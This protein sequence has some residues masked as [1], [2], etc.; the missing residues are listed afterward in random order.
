M[1]RY[2]TALVLL[3]LT[4]GGLFPQSALAAL[5]RDGKNCYIFVHGKQT[6][7]QSYY[8][9]GTAR[10]YWRDPTG[11]SGGTIDV[12]MIY[13]YDRRSFYVVNYNGTAA[14]WDTTAGGTVAWQI[15]NAT[16]GGSD[17]GGNRCAYS[18]TQGG[19]FIVIAHSMG[20]TIMDAILGNSR[21]GDTYYNY[22]GYPLSTVAQR[23]AYVISLAGAHRGSELADAVCGGRSSACGFIAW[24]VASCDAATDWLQTRNDR[25]VNNFTNAPARNIWLIGGYR[26]LLAS[27]A[28][29]SGED[30]GAVQYASQFA[31]NGLATTAYGNA[32][33]CGNTFKQKPSGFLNVDA[34]YE[35]H[36]QCKDCSQWGQRIAVTDGVWSC[37]ATRCP[38]GTIMS[39][40]WATCS[41]LAQ[42]GDQLQ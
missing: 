20:A 34:A 29:L 23:I 38:P 35:D 12:M 13:P 8:D 37:G 26:G 1:R 31:C 28:C 17:N 41:V 5:P 7:T 4:L 19:R 27:S 18:Y 40:G 10:A 6:T 9:W 3:A 33:P 30:D 39:S 25:A 11:Y 42:Y 24:W 16:N 36:F 32:W 2:H 22:M 15:V 14:W 21:P